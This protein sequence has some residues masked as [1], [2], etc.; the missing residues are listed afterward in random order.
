[1]KSKILFYIAVGLAFLTVSCDS[2]LDKEPDDMQTIEGV[3]AKRSTTEQ[4]LANAYAYLPEQ[5]DAVCIVPPMY[6]WPFVPASDEAE[7]GAV[8]VYAFMQNGTLSASNPS[9]NFWTPLYRGIRET[10]V[11]LEHV[12]E[13]KELED[14]ELEA[15]TAEARFVMSWK[16]WLTSCHRL[17]EILT[18]VNRPVV[19]PWPIVPVYYFIRQVPYL[20]VMLIFHR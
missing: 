17:R 12:G 11:F 14:G 7:W 9:L 19:L 15:W 8:R 10:N 20:T 3:F 18:K 1:M 4:Y 6:G 5:Y 2:Y 16:L 13:C